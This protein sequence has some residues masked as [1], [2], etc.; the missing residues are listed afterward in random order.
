[1]ASQTKFPMIFENLKSILKPYASKLTLK[2]NVNEN[3]YLEGAYSQKWKKEL[4]RK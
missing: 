2:G 4:L 3:F 1:M